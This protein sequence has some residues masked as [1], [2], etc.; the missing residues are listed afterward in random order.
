M[1]KFL[2]AIFI[3]SLMASTGA[4]GQSNYT[5]TNFRLGITAY[6]DISGTGTAIPMSDNTSGSSNAPQEIGFSFNFNGTPFTQFMIHADG[7]LKLGNTAPGASTDI[8]AN[9]G[10]AYGA[11]FTS[12]A[13]GFQN[14]IMPLFTNLIQGAAVPQFHVLTTGVAPNRVCT[15]QWKNLADADNAGTAPSQFSNLEFQVKLYET[16]NDI[17]FVYGNFTPSANT[18]AARNAVSGIKASSSSFLGLYKLN[19]LLPFSKVVVFNPANHGRIT[20]SFAFRNTVIPAQGFSQT[21]FGR[22]TSDVN[23]G[24]IYFDSIAPKGSQTAG[25][26]EALI[27]NEGTAVANNIDVTLNISGSNIANGAVN[28]ASLA[29]GASQLVSFPAFDLPN[30]GQQDVQVSVNSA[31][32]ERAANNTMTKQQVIS[33]TH[34]QTFDFSTSSNLGVGFTVANNQ[35]AVKIY[36]TGT[37]KV[38]QVR[39]P[40][41]TYR[42]LV[43]VRIFEDGGA[44]GAPSASPIFTSSNFFTTTEHT[45]VVPLGDG[46]TV[47]GDYYVAVQQT[48]ASNMGWRI[49]INPPRR[50]A[51]NYSG[52]S[53]GTWNL[54]ATTPPWENMLEV[55]E[56]SAASDIGIERLVSPA[57]DYSSAADVKVILRNY[58]ATPVDFAANPTNI[59]GTMIQP[60]GA[61]LPF[62][63]PKSSGVLPAFGSEEITVL[64]NYDYAKRGF[65][66][67]SARTN[68]SGDTETNNDS[69]AFFI[70]NSIVI[71]SSAA[72]PVCP[73]TTVTLTGV[74]YLGS[75]QWN[76]EGSVSSGT[77]PRVIVPQKNTVVKFSG[78]D[79]RGCTLVD[80]IIVE[81][82]N[83]NLPEKPILIFGDTLLTHRNAFKDTVRVKKLAGHT[84]EWLGG[85]GNVTS[86][87]ALIINQIAGMTGVQVAAAYRRTS[88]GCANLSDT[89]GYS[90]GA[91]VLH[92]ENNITIDVCDTSF[93]DAG[94]P[95]A[96]TGGNITR[97][98]TP[99]TPG[100]KLKLT[101]YRTDLSNFASIQVYDGTSASAPRIEALSN[102]QNGNTVREFIASNEG[103]ALTVQFS[104]GS[105][106][107][108][109]WWAGITCYE[110]E[111]YRTVSSGNWLTAANWERKAPGGSYIP[112]VRSP[113]KGDDTV[114]I[115]HLMNLSISNP[116]DQIIVEE[117][118]QLDIENPGV[119]FISMP[120]Y[121]TT[122]QPEFLVKGIL[123]ISPRVQ[124]FGANGQMIVQGRL[125]NFGQID[126]DSVV[127]NGTTPQ[128]L[129]NFSGASG[130]M[131]RL[132]LN[133]AAGLTMGSDQEVTGISFVNGIINSNSENIITL[134]A[135]TSA[136]NMGHNG[137]HI[138]GPL[139]VQLSGGNG[140]RLFPIGKNGKYRPVHLN[141]SN[142]N[143]ESSDK[144]TA[145][146]FEGAP[147]QRTLP[148]GINKVSELRYYKITRTGNNG[149]DFIVILPYGPDDGVT[150]PQNLTIAKDNGAGAWINI[151]GLA[152][153]S[154]IGEI[155]SDQFNEF[156][157]FVL[158]NKTG[159][160]NPLPVVWKEF[161][162]TAVQ[163]DAQ[164][165]WVT[166][167]EN[168]CRTF[169]VERSRDGNSFFSIGD[170][171]CHNSPGSQV[172]RFVDLNPGKGTFYYRLKQVDTDGKFNYSVVRRVSFG[173]SGNIEAHPN[174]V[175]ETLFLKNIPGNSDIRLYDASGR[176]VL[177]T[178]Q[179]QPV[180]S[181]QVNHLPAGLYQVLVTSVTGER[182]VQ[183]IQIIR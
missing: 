100:K 97:T 98:F 49:N 29:A 176:L 74:G 16:T 145:E 47:T 114:Y 139:T 61:Q 3:I 163:A 108:Q 143:G 7:I 91:G 177:F 183:K 131:K 15:I 175:R 89:I 90:Y 142:S 173:E 52:N 67:I 1:L 147:P 119:N 182:L 158:A 33:Q 21:F 73:L 9:P 4:N 75:P 155:M 12:N 39:I 31:G 106:Q 162:A 65:H 53:F 112:A 59:T 6:S 26:V 109:G 164:L 166:A 30:K 148:D 83:D 169:E 14:I 107:S 22:L 13:A 44:G 144:F 85:I 156:S 69:L 28:I 141:N 92:N 140:E 80:S 170:R 45:M 178:R 79:Y 66:R 118:G 84:I 25:R 17:E 48:T 174:P 94:G 153:G 20:S 63:I 82:T 129:G 23:V 165:D 88:D 124:I 43:N 137:S 127:F 171:L 56:E 70:N 126:L 96:N 78:I 130:S 46:V 51:R 37:R 120:A 110:S 19:S 161:T 42:N 151:G 116:M 159:G 134:R 99:S 136:E 77:N 160:F 72:G 11:V 122:A 113:Q 105:F 117:T 10:S 135:S 154:A 157:D 104:V 2:P 34:H 86:D 152:N 24:K 132:H 32:D 128:I 41:G 172:Y 125:N 62:T 123:N 115:R 50:N 103:G 150:D 27:V 18:A 167:T 57:C 35:T 5:Q 81:V 102:A 179:A 60:D 93:Y 55:Y 101:F 181:L 40:F 54:D 8:A 149:L 180:I 58:S 95:N 121:K 64:S 111:V 68:L 138:N 87:S 133:N 36:G 146:V 168:R 71:T 76:V 38:M